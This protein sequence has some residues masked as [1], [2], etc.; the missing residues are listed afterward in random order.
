MPSLYRPEAI[1]GQRQ[2]WLGRIQLV[3][4]LSLTV[5]TACAVTAALAVGAFL[6]VGD[7]TRKARVSG[8]LA[9]DRGLIR[10]MPQQAGTLLERHA[11]EGQYVHAGDALFVLSVDRSTLSGDSQV[12]VQAAL[13]ARGR[14]LQEASRQQAALVAEQGSALDRRLADMRRESSQIGAE[15]GLHRKRLELA[16]ASLGR[17]QDLQ[18]SNFISEA[19]VQTK[20]EEVLGLEAQTQALERQLATQQREI[21][22]VEAQRRELPLRL[23]VQQ[24]EIDRELAGLAQE[25]AE[26]A[27]RQ[28]IVVRA[29][30]DGLLSAVTVEPGQNVT[31]GIAL[32]TLLPNDA[33]LQAHLYAPSSAVG[34]VHPQQ[35]VQLRYQ[36]YPYQK[37]GLQA[38]RVLD[39][40]R[41][42]LQA[43]ELSSL[44]L[45]GV[46]TGAATVAGEPLYRITVA[47]DRQSVQAYGR[48]QPLTPGMQ[49][50]ADVLLDRR[51]LIEWL[52]EPVLG[53][54]G[55]V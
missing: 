48:A 21:G 4:P 22:V 43:S 13:D 8:Y 23:Q 40:S 24:G 20:Q 25:G 18:K 37:F 15:I 27:A 42:P 34:F 41:T 29:P 5:L 3:R 33:V 30:A 16:R 47:L 10:L 26:S 46:V 44:P 45:A 55:R 32:A 19:Q 31:P 35:Q 6:F 50:D 17:L 54:T 51:R 7:Y 39:V 49:I 14:S 2:A 11:S 52:F 36:A 9:P 1:E 38:G 12:G 28:R 53:L